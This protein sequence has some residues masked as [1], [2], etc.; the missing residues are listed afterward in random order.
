MKTSFLF[1]TTL[2]GFSYTTIAQVNCAETCKTMDVSTAYS[3][4]MNTSSANNNLLNNSTYANAIGSPF[5]AETFELSKIYSNNQLIGTFYTRYNAFSREIEVKK[6]TLKEEKSSI[7]NKSKDI[8]IVCKNEEIQYTSFIDLKGK[9]HTD[10]LVTIANGDK[11]GLFKRVRVK[12]RSGQEAQN[13]YQ[14]ATPG[15]FTTSTE[16]FISENRA[17]LISQV[18]IKKS[19]LVD[20]FKSDDKIQIANL[21]KKESL[22][23]NKK[24]DLITILNFANTLDTDYVLTN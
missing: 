19:K 13:S 24:E 17:N 3:N 21:I 14:K 5:I 2:L 16:Y 6:T 22:R 8:K 11:Y 7:L 20:F 12:F 1:L 18:S 9:K 15:R 4:L 10:Y 23:T